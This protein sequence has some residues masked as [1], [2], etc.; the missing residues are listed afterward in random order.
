MIKAMGRRQVFI[1]T[2]YRAIQSHTDDNDCSTKSVYYAF[3]CYSS[4]YWYFVIL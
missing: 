1:I 2:D 4:P 3:M